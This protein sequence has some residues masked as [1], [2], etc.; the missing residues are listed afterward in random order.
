MVLLEGHYAN[1]PENAPASL[2]GVRGRQERFLPKRFAKSA[3]RKR[4]LLVHLQRFVKQIRNSSRPV[5]GSFS[6]EPF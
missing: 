1:M 5:G 2:L 4:L 6:R 3:L